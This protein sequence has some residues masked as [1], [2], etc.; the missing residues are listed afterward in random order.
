MKR[1]MTFAPIDQLTTVLAMKFL[2]GELEGL[3]DVQVQWANFT[4]FERYSNTWD[5]GYPLGTSDSVIPDQILTAQI[6]CHA[7]GGCPLQFDVQYQ[8]DAMLKIERWQVTKVTYVP[9]LDMKVN[10]SAERPI[11]RNYDPLRGMNVFIVHVPPS[12][13]LFDD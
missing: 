6:M 1:D 12:G 4:W 7:G 11:V 5:Y 9:V 10:S 3:I 2:R 8:I 13:G